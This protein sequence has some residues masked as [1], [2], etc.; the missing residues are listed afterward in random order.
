MARPDGIGVFGGTFNPIHLGHLRAAEEVREAASLAEIRFVPCAV[1]PHKSTEGLAPARARLDMLDLAV[2]GVPGFRSWDVEL[3]RPGPSY[4][5]DTLEILR[6]EL[7]AQARIVFIVGRDAFGDLATWRRYDRL[8]ALCDLVVMTR[9]P[10]T[11]PLSMDDLPVAVRQAFCYDPSVGGFRHESGHHVTSLSIS[12][13]AISAT[14][15]RRRVACGQSI[16]FLVPSAVE[17]Y[18]IEHRLYRSGPPSP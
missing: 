7:G 15:I 8:F 5:V 3:G 11:H 16:R 14:D 18:V 2:T 9:P 4:S 17:T 1:P 6:G 12:S 13:L 10:D